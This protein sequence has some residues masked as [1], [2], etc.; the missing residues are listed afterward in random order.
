[1]P[2]LSRK[3]L[4]LIIFTVL[5]LCSGFAIGFDEPTQRRINIGLR[6]FSTLLASDMRLA[7]KL[8]A[9][10]ELNI[11]LVVRD[12]KSHAEDLSIN[13]LQLGRERDKGKINGH[14][15]KVVAVTVSELKAM[16]S[17]Q[18][19]GIFVAELFSD[20]VLNQI[21]GFGIRKQLI[22]YSPFEGDVERGILGGIAVGLRVKPYLNQS[23]LSASKIEIKPLFIKVSKFY[24]DD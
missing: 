21:I 17:E 23:T 10:N 4:S 24:N 18:I 16:E 5:L 20:Q 9:E 14:P 11:I 6:L 2:C 22:S 15:L 12:D 13:F 19:A 3:T 7:E 1:M 8:N